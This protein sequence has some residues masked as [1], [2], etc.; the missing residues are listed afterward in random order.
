MKHTHAVEQHYS[1]AWGP[2]TMRIRLARG[3]I[4]ELPED[5]C[6]LLFESSSRLDYATC[7]MSQPGDEEALELFL[8][9]GSDAPHNDE[10]AELLTAFAHYHRIGA[11]LGLQNS[12]GWSNRLCD[13]SS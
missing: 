4:H 3:R 13:S 12:S 9:A 7:G 1:Q 11:R 5:F 6:V 8:L 10:M 2:P